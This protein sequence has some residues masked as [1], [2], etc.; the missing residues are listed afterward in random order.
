MHFNGSVANSKL[1]QGTS[2]FVND[3]GYAANRSSQYCMNT[4]FGLKSWKSLHMYEIARWSR[5]EIL[6]CII[7]LIY[8]LRE[9]LLWINCAQGHN[10][11]VELDPK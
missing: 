2:V 9:C 1:S 8:L 10:I 7:T 3:F 5:A 4:A 11:S 6:S